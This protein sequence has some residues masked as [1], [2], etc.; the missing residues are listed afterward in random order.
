LIYINQTENDECT[1]VPFEQIMLSR[2]AYNQLK[3]QGGAILTP[4][5]SINI[6]NFR[7]SLG[8]L[9][10]GKR[11]RETGLST[12]IK[13]ETTATTTP[14][15]SRVSSP[16]EDR[17]SKRA[18]ST[19]PEKAR[20]FPQPILVDIKKEPEHESYPPFFT[21]ASTASL[22]TPTMSRARID[23]S[24]IS[25]SS[26]TVSLKTLREKETATAP[27]KVGRR[28]KVKEAVHGTSSSSKK[29][30]TLRPKKSEMR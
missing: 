1:T 24:N 4:R 14:F 23:K 13:S 8:N 7:V 17:S 19:K 15:A 12:S 16:S 27:A 20:K 28:K 11:R 29:R 22:V 6:F 21:L 18:R 2:L 5:H 25:L 30:N 3:K 10:T 9:Q 26:S